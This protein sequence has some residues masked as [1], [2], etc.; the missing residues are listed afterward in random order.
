MLRRLLAVLLCRA[1]RSVPVPVL[2]QGLWGDA[3]PRSARK[4]LQVYVRR[5]RQTLGEDGRIVYGEGGYAATVTPDEID[6]WRFEKLA[7]RGR[8]AWSKADLE[9]AGARLEEALELWRGPAYAGLGEVP[10]IADEARRLAE[11]RSRAREDLLAVKVDLGRHAEVVV[12]LSGMA[13]ELPYRER[14]C[15]LLMVS[16]YRTGRQ[17]EAL[18]VFR[19]AHAT[20]VEELGVQPSPLLRRIHESILREDEILTKPAQ[21][22][23]LHADEPVTSAFG[24]MAAARPDSGQ[25]TKPVP[26]VEPA[27][28]VPALLPADIE[29]FTGRGEQVEFLLERLSGD[30]RSPAVPVVSVVG[31][32][33]VGKT[34][35]AVHVAHRLRAAFPDGQLYVDLHGVGDGTG[36]PADPNEVL[37]RFLTT[38]GM[39]GRALPEGLEARAESYRALVAGRRILVVLDNAGDERQVRPLLPGSATCAVMMTSRRRL[40]GLSAHVLELDGFDPQWAQVLLERVAGAERVAAEPEAT[41]EI[42]ELCDHLPLAIRIAG[43]RLAAREHWSLAHLSRL[44]RDERR[45]LDEL[46]VGDLSVRASLALGYGALTA[47]ERRAF[48]LLALLDAPT[49][50]SWALAAVV[51]CSVEQAD[52]HIDELLDAG[53]LRFTGTDHCGQFRY[54]FHDLVRLYGRECAEAEETAGERVGALTRAL[55][56]WLTVA[57]MADNGLTERVVA[58]VRGTAPRWKPDQRTTRA[59]VAD[60]LAWFDSERSALVACVAQACHAGL[61]E[62]AWELSACVVNY[63]AFRGLHED[64]KQT[65]ELALDMCIRA[66]N[67]L[68]KAVMSR[69]LGFLRVVG[70]RTSPL[71]AL[72]NKDQALTTFRKLGIQH[73]EVDVLSLQLFSLRRKGDYDGALIA[74]D[75]AMSQAERIDYRLGQA[76]L[77]Y[78]RALINRER[79]HYDRAIA[80]AR[81]SLDLAQETGSAY[82]RVLA[83]WELAAACRDEETAHQVIARLHDGL[84]ECDQRG[85]R[86]LRAYHELALGDLH[87]RFERPGARDLLLSGLSVL[88]EH[89]VLFGQGAGLRMLGQLVH[90]LNRPKQAVAHLAKAVE[91]SAKLRSIHEHALA[92]KALGHA[93]CSLGAPNAALASWWRAHRLFE[94]IPN[95]VEAATLTRLLDAMVS[96]DVAA[97]AGP[98]GSMP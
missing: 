98:Q 2:L 22:I 31:R 71:T 66:H 60:P 27:T 48:R 49:F 47:E 78:M 74:A 54:A 28:A 93:Q 62:L 79:G 7:E 46:A 86:L 19:R 58:D 10:T 81:R 96:G 39:Q 80:C 73:G 3:P 21:E 53:L 12:D 42:A 11:Q 26:Q 44:L 50:T 41:M 70:L 25:A 89:R 8:Y 90:A 77:W 34:T 95:T 14:L 51:D 63:L 24:R 75:R 91:I 1:G 69:N 94:R 23:L 67:D 72:D 15:A 18:Q 9:T 92:L 6:S 85:E 38:L 64:W 88:N 13:D 97:C 32:A 5:L 83:L 68:G 40:G 87:R 33:G 37:G 56:A 29:D 84:A 55:G 61:D 43:A 36:T 30:R 16:L 35:L 20:L 82:E 17:A 57:E 4:T 52:E 59:L 76:R 45:R 65:H